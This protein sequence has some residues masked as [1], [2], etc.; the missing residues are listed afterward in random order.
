MNANTVAGGWDDPAIYVDCTASCYQAQVEKNLESGSYDDYGFELENDGCSGAYPCMTISGNTATDNYEVGFYLD[1]ENALITGNTATHNGYSYTG[2]TSDYSGFYVDW[3]SNTL[4]KNTASANACDGFYVD[5]ADNTLSGNTAT[6][7]FVHGFQV[8]ADGNELDTNTATGNMGDGFN[9][10]GTNTVFTNNKASGN[11]QDCT[12]DNQAPSSEGAS[13]A[14]STGNTCADTHVFN[15][16][17]TL[18]GW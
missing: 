14:T 18:T 7:N 6:G 3:D 4:T 8:E 10:D 13:I 11:R 9:N 5:T 2:C 15:W 16:A 1:T 12:N 17:S